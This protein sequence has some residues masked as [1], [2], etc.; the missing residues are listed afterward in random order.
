MRNSN[1]Y[2]NPTQLKERSCS[3]VSNCRRSEF[4]NVELMQCGWYSAPYHKS[5]F[6]CSQTSLAFLKWMKNQICCRNCIFIKTW[7]FCWCHVLLEYH[8]WL[9][10]TENNLKTNNYSPCNM[11]LK[12]KN[13]TVFGHFV[14]QKSCLHELWN[15]LS[16]RMCS[17]ASLTH[18]LWEIWNVSTQSWE[19]SIQRK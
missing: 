4:C 8:S 9:N 3:H 1:K 6:F 18:R 12:K 13:S 15:Q 11:E 17:K 2:L 14:T 16:F 5:S 19:I 10:L 7:L